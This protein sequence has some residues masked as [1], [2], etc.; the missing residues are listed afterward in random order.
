MGLGAENIVN[1]L[2]DSLSIEELEAALYR[3]KGIGK[4]AP[5]PMS[6]K[7]RLLEGYRRRML[8]LGILHPPKQF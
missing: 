3:K 7:E 2:V 8:A 1:L 6:E 4:P 5:K